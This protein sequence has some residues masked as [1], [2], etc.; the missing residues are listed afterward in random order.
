M[1][2]SA[3]FA[4]AALLLVAL[5]SGVPSAR[6]DDAVLDAAKQA[7]SQG[8]P[9]RASRLLA[10]AL[11]D[12]GG[13]TPERLLVAARAAN[14]WGGASEV[15]RLLAGEPWL[16][17]M[18]DREG[19]AL[20]AQAALALRQD[21]AAAR[22]A[23]LAVDGARGV[24][25]AERTVILARALD[26]LEQRDSAAAA[27]L[28]AADGLPLIADW[29]RL[30]AAIVTADSGRR[31]QL[32]AAIASPLPRARVPFAEAQARERAGDSVGAAAKYAAMGLP[33]DALRLQLPAADV[34]ARAPLRRELLQ[35]IEKRPGSEDARQ[36]VALLDLWTP[37]LTAQE[38]LLV[39][40]ALVRGGDAARAGAAYAAAAKGG[41]ATAPDR[42]DYGDLLARLGQYDRALAIF[43]P[44]RSDKK[45]GA[46]AAYRMARAYV[47]KGDATAGQEIL[48]TLPSRYPH[49]TA[50]AA[51]AL[52]LQGDL[53]SD[54]RDDSVARARWRTL[55]KKYPTAAQV[56]SAR[57]RAAIA[58]LVL[59]APK[60]AAAELDTLAHKHPRSDDAGP[61]LYWAGRAQAEL[62]DTTAARERWRKVIERDVR[63]YYAALAEARLGETPWTPAA[64]R[65]SFAVFPD[66]DS[67]M[68]RAALCARLGLVPE[69]DREYARAMLDADVS[70]ERQL[71]TAAAF[72]AAER[73]PSSITLALRAS[74][75]TPVPDARVFRLL[76][77]LMHGDALAAEATA[78][79]LT[80][81]FVA[82]LVRQESWFDPKALSRA[83]ARGL[84]QLLPDVGRVTAKSL[85]YPLWDPVLLYEPDVNLELGTAHLAELKARFPDTVRL[86]AAYNAGGNRVVRWAGKAGTDDPEL[87]AERIPFT[88]TRDYVR[89]IQRNEQLYRMLYHLE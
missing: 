50:S 21:T 14:A 51:L 3:P 30:R 5:P 16:D 78:R 34:E 15:R 7:L 26:R 52:F 67:T 71:A 49:D 60:T 69:S 6:R 74:A 79:G 37:S 10:P 25:R 19:R 31:A 68:T 20:L 41:V 18:F 42:L 28:A 46:S 56:P 89:V 8:R 57:F 63:S 84:M 87:F 45:V 58:A 77:P 70:V 47:R 4:L 35:I 55:V 75:R 29:L 27:Y 88:E 86:L 72:R 44:L 48:R 22:D 82:A 76:Y 11:R 61:A 33:L 17:R 24:T 54:A 73:G 12:S 13:R 81:A 36:A 59:G 43:R 40:R 64:A 39:A 23:A 2:S 62:G 53:A 80:P 9:W 85:G 32:F 38:Q 66:L 1:T 65:D 83:N